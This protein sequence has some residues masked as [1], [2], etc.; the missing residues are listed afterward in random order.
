MRQLRLPA[1]I[2][3]VLILGLAATPVLAHPGHDGA[4]LAAGL[5]HPLT[6]L[7]HLLAMVAVGVLAAMRGGP[8]Q[9][10]WPAAFLA[11]MLG[12]IALGQLAPGAAL[13]PMILTSVI[14]LGGLL[15]AS[16][17]VPA[18][19]GLLLM[20]AF[21]LAH[22]YAHG[23]EGPAGGYGFP[24]GVLL[25]TAGLHAAGLL[26]GLSLKTRPAVAR[27]LGA[28]AALSGVVLAVAA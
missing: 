17:R 26:A 5:E 28:G 10:A 12:G 24:A 15:A 7:D 19:L 27:L 3:P 6:G 13:E 23:V 18:V 22:G 11:A 1:L 20:T 2:L 16:V 14:V 25:T 9:W 4:S 21:G 8:S